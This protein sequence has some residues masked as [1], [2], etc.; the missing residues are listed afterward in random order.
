MI[1]VNQYL[2]SPRGPVLANLFMGY[3]KT[4]WLN[5][6]QECEII[7]QRRYVDG[8]ICLFNCEP[9]TDKFFEFLNIQRPNIKFT[10]EK[11]AHKEISFLY[12]L[13]TNDGDQFCISAFHKETAIGFFTNCLGFTLFSCKVGFVRTLLHHTFMISGGWFLFHEEIVKIKLP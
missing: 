12:V 13:I 9:D 7:Q 11:Q 2:G 4:I 5:T 10:F 8:V 1:S 6:F 3:Y